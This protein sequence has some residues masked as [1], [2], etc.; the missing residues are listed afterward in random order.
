MKGA[1]DPVLVFRRRLLAWSETFV[2]RQAR[3]LP[4]RPAAFAG[5]GEDRSGRGLLGDAPVYLQDEW[6]ARPRLARWRL[7]LSGR[8]D[9]RWLE[10]IRAARPALVHA[11]FVS[12]GVRARALADALGVPLVVTCHGYDVLDETLGRRARARRAALLAAADRIVAVS[13]FLAERTVALGAP[14]ARV[15]RHHIGTPLG[16]PR[17]DG[18]PAPGPHALF[19]GRLIPAKGCAHALEAFARVRARL[20]GAT[21]EVIGDGPERAALERRAA[22]IGGV[23][24]RGV[25]GP[26]ELEAAWRTA[27]AL[28]NPSRA[29]ANGWRE[30]FGLVFV[31]AQ[32]AG[33]PAIGYASGGVVEAVADGEGG[34]TVPEGD[35]A[36]LAERLHAVLADDA[37]HAALARAGRARVERRF[38]LAVQC[39]ALEGIYRDVLAGR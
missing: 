4:T 8:P 28:C 6:A 20:P 1:T 10:A 37:L 5:L 21:L 35:V 36:A 14:R 19:V 22:S 39:R 30:A 9:P 24:F 27:R 13:D 38:D 23:R 16:A 12:S 2:A 18:A 29:G 17:P 31:E 32:A 7:S 34:Y 25:L 11:H 33:V 26:V 15:V 3:G